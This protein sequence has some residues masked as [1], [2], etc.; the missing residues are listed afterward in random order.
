ML[1]ELSASVFA[2]IVE[3]QPDVVKAKYNV[4]DFDI[5]SALRKA[6]S[7]LDNAIHSHR[8]P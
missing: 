7:A 2:G 3:Q 8:I 1:V 6:F 5:H 4:L